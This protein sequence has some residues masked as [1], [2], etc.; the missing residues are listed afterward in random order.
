MSSYFYVLKC[1][2][3]AF[4]LFDV[5]FKAQPIRYLATENGNAEFHF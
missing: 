1:M 2:G 5:V 3:A 4:R